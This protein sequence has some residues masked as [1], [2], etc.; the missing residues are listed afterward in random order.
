M[1]FFCQKTFS[2]LP[3]L[4][5]QQLAPPGLEEEEDAGLR[6]GELDVVDQQSEQDEVRER[7]SEVHN[8]PEVKEQNELN[9]RGGET[10]CQEVLTLPWFSASG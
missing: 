6:S 2:H 1:Y 5:L 3:H 8:L 9:F 10:N 7:G 4:H